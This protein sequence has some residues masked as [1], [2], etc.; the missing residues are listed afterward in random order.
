MLVM[1]VSRVHTYILLILMFSVHTNIFVHA[2]GQTPN[3]LVRTKQAI[4]FL[5]GHEVVRQIADHG[6]GTLSLVP[7]SPRDNHQVIQIPRFA[8]QATGIGRDNAP[9]IGSM[10]NDHSLELEI[11]LWH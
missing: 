2:D 7:E 11:A 4:V 10:A 3:L 6:R 5:N 8:P 9:P 1:L